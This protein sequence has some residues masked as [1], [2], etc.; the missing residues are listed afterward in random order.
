M[1]AELQAALPANALRM[2]LRECVL[3][4]MLWQ[5]QGEEWVLV[6]WN[7]A[8]AVF[9]GM[10]PCAKPLLFGSQFYRDCPQM[11]VMLAECLESK[12]NVQAKTDCRFGALLT[13]GAFWQCCSFIEPDMVLVQI[14]N[15]EKDQDALWDSVE[16]AELLKLLSVVTDVALILDGEGRY[17]KILPTK[18]VLLYKVPEEIL[19]RT[20]H[21]VFPAETADRFLAEIQQA[22]QTQ[23][24]VQLEYPLDI[25]EKEIW[26]SASVIPLTADRVFWVARDTTRQEMTEKQLQ[27]AMLSLE[28]SQDNVLWMDLYGKIFYANP[29]MCEDLGYSREEL[30]GMRVA[31]FDP[32]YPEEAWGPDGSLCQERKTRVGRYLQTQHRRRDG[33]MIPVEIVST[34]VDYRGQSYLATTARNISQRLE[35][36]RELREAKEQLEEKVAQR[37]RELYEANL[38]LSQRVEELQTLQSYLVRLGK[39]ADL[40][41]MVAGVAHEINT[42]LGMGLTTATHLASMSETLSTHVE[43]GTLRRQDLNDFIQDL[44]EAVAILSSNLEKAARLIRSFK[45]MSADQAG[46]NKREFNAGDHLKE[47]LLSIQPKLKKTKLEVTVECD[48]NLVINSYPGAFSQ[49][50]TNLILN[51]AMHGYDAATKGNIHIKA[52]RRN[53]QL[54]ITYTDDGKGMSPEIVGRVFEPF[55]T[56]NAAAGGTGL[57][58]FVVHNIVVKQLQGQVECFSVPGEGVRFVLSFPG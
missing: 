20:V 25:N 32:N 7:R 48:E 36:E 16:A 49:I 1:K 23:K 57:G 5:R 33:H 30:Y 31:D 17:L 56:T 14:Q 51:S 8:S 55:F 11:Q 4:L 38:E 54:F 52:E 47:L 34:T 26:F 13:A 40:G 10:E 37:T 24:T 29:K 44:Q 9:V 58:L 15:R 39:L 2:V 22:L 12:K 3:P 28:S 46:E 45:Q 19:G 53:E 27:L 18:P 21:E 43:Q 42:P 41:T 6:E 50:I 35:T